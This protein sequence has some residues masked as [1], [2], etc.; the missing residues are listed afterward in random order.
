[1]PWRLLSLVAIAAIGFAFF[2]FGMP[3]IGDATVSER[4]TARTAA[5]PGHG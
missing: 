1:M 3:E 2:L 5:V 4:R